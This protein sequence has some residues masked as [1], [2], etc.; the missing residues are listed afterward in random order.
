[1]TLPVLIAHLL[2]AVGC[3][4]ALSSLKREERICTTL[5]MMWCITVVTMTFLKLAGATI[6]EI[7]DFKS[8]MTTVSSALFAL[9]FIELTVAISR[10]SASLHKQ[11]HRE[12]RSGA[13]PIAF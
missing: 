3:V 6:P 13:D 7:Q 4:A 2:I 5:L 1:M 10:K 9:S 12:D 8:I 11:A